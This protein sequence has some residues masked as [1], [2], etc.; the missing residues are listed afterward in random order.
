MSN[1]PPFVHVLPAQQQF[2]LDRLFTASFLNSRLKSNEASSQTALTSETIAKFKTMRKL[3][4]KNRKNNVSNSP[5]VQEIQQQPPQLKYETIKSDQAF[6]N[7]FCPQPQPHTSKRY[8]R[9]KYKLLS[10]ILELRR[11]KQM[12]VF[13]NEFYES[14]AKGLEGDGAETESGNEKDDVR[15]VIISDHAKINEDNVKIE[16]KA[17]ISREDREYYFAAEKNLES[18]IRVRID[19]D[20]FIVSRGGSKIPTDWVE[21]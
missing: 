9:R 13:G 6:T 20:Q 14:V 21:G 15:E 18:L 1:K 2:E 3:K 16:Q 11:K 17:I 5:P 8:L 7:K 4:K 12:S 10:K 19:W